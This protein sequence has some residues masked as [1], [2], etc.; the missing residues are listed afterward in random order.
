ML[1]YRGMKQRLVEV[2]FPPAPIMT[3]EIH[4]KIANSLLLGAILWLKIS[5]NNIA[6]RLGEDSRDY[7]HVGSIHTTVDVWF[8]GDN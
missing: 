6:S 1:L 7:S 3:K 4:S 2:C 8:T 5:T